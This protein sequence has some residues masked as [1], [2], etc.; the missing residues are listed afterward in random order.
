MYKKLILSSM[1]LMAVC[2][3]SAK[4]V[5]PQEA[6]QRA[7]SQPADGISKARAS[8]GMAVKETVYTADKSPA[9]YLFEGEGQLMVL[10]ADDRMAP[11]LGYVAQPQGEMPPQM[12]WWLSEYAR[13]IE[14]VTAT[15]EKGSGLYITPRAMAAASEDR[16]PIAP[17]VT[18]RWDQDN[19]Y[20]YKCPTISGQKAMTGCVAT[21]AAQVMKYH[22]YPEEGTGTISYKDTDNNV[23]RTL[24]LTGKKFDWANMLDSYDGTYSSTQRDAVAF[25]MQ[26]VGYASQMAYGYDA[27]GAHSPDMVAGVKEYFGYNDAM[28]M[29]NRDNFPL[30]QWEQMVYDNLKTVGPVYYAGD[31]NIQGGHAFVCDG[32]SQDGFFHFNWGWGG[33]YD[34]YFKLTALTPEGQGIGG[35]AGGFNFGQ[36]IVLNFTKPGAPTI[37]TP[38]TTPITLTGNL[39]GTKNGSVKLNLTSDMVNTMGVFVYNSSG[40]SATVEFG[41]KA[42]NTATGEEAIKGAGTSVYLEPNYGR[43]TMTLTIPANLPTGNYKMHIVARDYPSGEWLPLNHGMSNV[44]YVNA[45]VSNGSLTSV[46]NASGAELEAY[47]IEVL[48]SVYLSYPVKLS[49]TLENNGETEIYDGVTPLIF[50]ISNGGQAVPKA[51]GDAFAADLLPGQTLDVETIATLYPYQGASSFSGSAYFGLVSNNTGTIFDYVPITVKSAPSTLAATSTQFTMQGDRNNADANDLKFD[52]GLKVTRGYWAAPLTVYICNTGGTMLHSLN[53]AETYF[54]DASQ[55]ASATVEGSFPNATQGTSYM[56]I[57]GYVSGYYIQD[58]ASLTFKVKTPYS[59]VEEAAA[60][61]LNPTV[62]IADRAAGILSVI[63]P[64]D[65]A[66]VEAWS[67]DGRRLSLDLSVDGS[68][69][70]APLST[71]PYGIILVKV[72]L[73]DGTVTTAKIAK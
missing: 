70:G 73:A 68:R 45:A 59:G 53:S 51:M 24:S 11:V 56:A 44:D 52:C 15:P 7:M 26:A 4:Q 16:A 33:M 43:T 31:D 6:L 42:V 29:L 12:R 27:S 5:S 37:A 48:S 28:V 69:A 23:T 71:L 63:A 25:L 9:L 67:L 64:S 58:L 60:E 2:G 61:E 30:A 40:E 57:F 41:I 32:Y 14:Y 35:N 1:A 54:L 21:A 39:T 18:T 50:T 34:G 62:V 55:T 19:P 66:A 3:M 17:M 49:Y 72:T 20:N 10:P 36:E 47:D 46:G 65:I 13:Q 38:A 8:A 22:N